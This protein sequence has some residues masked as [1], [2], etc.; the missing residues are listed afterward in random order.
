METDSSICAYMP[1]FPCAQW[2]NLHT[3][4]TASTAHTISTESNF[5]WSCFSGEFSISSKSQ[6]KL[7]IFVMKKYKKKNSRQNAHDKSSLKWLGRAFPM[8]IFFVANLLYSTIWH[9]PTDFSMKSQFCV[10]SNEQCKSVAYTPLR[11]YN[12]QRQRVL[13]VVYICEWKMRLAD[14]LS[15]V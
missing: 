12:T 1:C 8:E 5:L 11:H 7:G 2:G 10:M 9:W 4:V 15:S 14:I 6:Q 3:H 13:L